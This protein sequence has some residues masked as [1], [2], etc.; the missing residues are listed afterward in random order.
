MRC[1]SGA[2]EFQDTAAVVSVNITSRT[3]VALTAADFLGVQTLT[4][5]TYDPLNY[6]A[7]LLVPGSARRL[8]MAMF[9]HSLSGR[10]DRPGKT[11]WDRN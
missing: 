4:I 7:L 5:C 8:C 2:T 6:S 1:K 9:V 3:D 10:S 11:H